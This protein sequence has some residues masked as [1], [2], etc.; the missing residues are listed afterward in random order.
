MGRVK[1]GVKTEYSVP[2]LLP[3]LDIRATE[4]SEMGWKLMTATVS[5]GN[6]VDI[7]LPSSKLLS[8]T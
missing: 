8:V 7:S 3:Y 6:V 5:S 1:S 4:T 2:C